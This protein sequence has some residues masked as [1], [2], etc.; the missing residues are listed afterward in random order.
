VLGE[1]YGWILNNLTFVM[2]YQDDRQNAIEFGR[3]ALEH[4]RTIGNAI[5]LGAAYLVLGSAYHQNGR[6]NEALG[7][8]QE[9][10]NIFEP[11][12]LN[13]WLGQIYSWR[14][15]TYLR[16]GQLIEAEGDLKK[17]LEIG[18]PNMGA[19]TLNRLGR[20]YFAQEKWDLA[21]AYFEKSY[22]RATETLDFGYSFG[23]LGKLIMIAAKKGQY[24][25][26]DEFEQA[27]K[28][29]KVRTSDNYDLGDAYFSM[30]TLALGQK[31]ISRVIEYLEK[32]VTLITEAG[33]S[34]RAGALSKLTRFEKN[35]EQIAPE[36]IR[37]IGQRLKDIL[38]KKETEN[39]EYGAVTPITYRWANWAKE[40]THEPEQHVSA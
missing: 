34:G 15:S 16:S 13:D 40:E 21:E 22:R 39:I 3:A 8:F 6:F 17:A 28:T 26:I 27:I 14:G 2:A 5:G 24:N 35:F 37:Q 31:D 25:R 12:E 20:V 10:L 33:V 9:A 32:G 1:D 19:M 23:S 18:P 36:T 4:W 7:S 30:A 29:S 38:V 11:L